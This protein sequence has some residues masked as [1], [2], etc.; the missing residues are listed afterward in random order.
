METVG[1]YVEPEILDSAKN[2]IIDQHL[3]SEKARTLLTWESKYSLN[4]GLKLT[5]D[6]Y[7]NYLAS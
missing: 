6:W 4:E 1:K 5:V 2:E 7:R 3:S